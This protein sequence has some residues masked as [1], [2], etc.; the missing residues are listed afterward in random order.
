MIRDTNA[1]SNGHGGVEHQLIDLVA[2]AERHQGHIFDVTF[3]LVGRASDD[4][5]D[6]AHRLHL[7]EGQKQRLR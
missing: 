3:R 1:N 5:V 7:D 2:E 6:F 4:H